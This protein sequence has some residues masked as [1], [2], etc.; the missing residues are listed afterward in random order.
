MK[1]LSGGL[2]VLTRI[3]VM[4]KLE[5]GE[6][7]ICEMH[8]SVPEINQKEGEYF[9]YEFARE[10]ETKVVHDFVN[11]MIPGSILGFYLEED[12]PLA[13]INRAMLLSLG[14]RTEEEYRRDIDGKLSMAIHPDD[15]KILSA[16]VSE[17]MTKGEVD[18]AVD[19]LDS[20]VE[21]P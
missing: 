5:N 2:A 18:E 8:T 15:R 21:V 12:M 10:H 9:P 14:Y 4:T 20:L 7:R 13:M 11:S 1:I 19:Y 17:G 3:T 6:S 16:T